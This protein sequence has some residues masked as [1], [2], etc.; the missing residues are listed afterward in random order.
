MIEYLNKTVGECLKQTA[1]LYPDKVAFETEDWSCTFKELDYITDLYAGRMMNFY[2]IHKGSHVG[3]WCVNTPSFAFTFFALQKIGAIVSAFNT[4]YKAEEMIKVLNKAEIEILFYGSGCKDIVYDDLLPVIRKN[5]SGV[6]HFLRIDEREGGVWMS[7][8][9]FWHHEKAQSVLEGVIAA[10]KEVTVQDESCIIFTSGST[11]DPKGVVLTHYNVVNDVYHVKHYMH[12]SEK[13]K[14]CCPAGWF[15]CFGLITGLIGCVVN[16]FALHILPYFR[17]KTVWNAIDKFHCT[18]MIGVPS[19][20]L[21]LIRKHEY[22]GMCGL[23]LTSGIVGGSPLPAQDY[24]DIC[25]RFPNMHLQT[26]FGM[27]EASAS[28]SFSDWDDSIESKAV[29]TG[30]VMEGIECRI[31]D[32][33]SGKQLSCGEHGEIQLKGFN[34]MKEY[35]KQ[36]EE[37]LKAFTRDGWLRTGDIGYMNS[38]GELCISGRLKEMIIRAGENISPTEIEEVIMRSGMVDSV[39]VVAVPSSF[40]QEEVAACVVP[41]NKN[42]LD[43]KK[44]LSF[45]QPRLASYKIPDYILSFDG[46]PMTASGK[47]DIKEIK[48]EAR[49]RCMGSEYENKA[50]T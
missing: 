37:T 11:S 25:S 35:Y 36:P 8:K 38:K 12:W 5:A 32:M 50:E 2:G 20:Y 14:M 4:Y 33:T 47:V 22:D 10:Q 48:K 44:L 29:T 39:K 27:T 16:G 46:F 6:A 15:H 17:T 18:I 30:C 23:S 49:E 1:K 24:I 9:S 43:S 21:A 28:V 41:K 40:R 7:E 31:V 3:I 19:M 45:M 13:D 42:I 26:S 34:I